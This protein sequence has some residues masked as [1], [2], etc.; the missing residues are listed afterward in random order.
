VA[1]QVETETLRLLGHKIGDG[2]YVSI[3]PATALIAARRAR[4]VVGRYTRADPALTE[5]EARQQRIALVA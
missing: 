4:D 5:D 2:E 1:K 3:D